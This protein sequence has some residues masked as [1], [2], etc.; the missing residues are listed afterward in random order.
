MWRRHGP[1]S[2]SGPPLR[3]GAILATRRRGAVSILPSQPL[4][5]FWID[6]FLFRGTRIAQYLQH[7]LCPRIPGSYWYLRGPWGIKSACQYTGPRTKLTS[8]VHT[9]RTHTRTSMPCPCSSQVRSCGDMAARVAGET[10]GRSERRC[11][12]GTTM[13]IP[14]HQHFRCASV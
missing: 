4:P 9:R 14:S 7:Y 5:R 8:S 10:L 6:S 2:Q 13:S 3:A 11:A 1:T 12:Q